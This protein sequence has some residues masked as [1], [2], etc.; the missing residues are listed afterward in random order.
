M[1]VWKFENTKIDTGDDARQWETAGG[2]GR[3]RETTG[4][5]RQRETTGEPTGNNGR[6]RETAGDSGRRAT[7]GDNGRQRGATGQPPISDP[8]PP[9]VALEKVYKILTDKLPLCFRSFSGEP[10]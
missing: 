9:T 8:I 1:E 10:M 3:K 5:G 7:T 4:D 2:N 6:E